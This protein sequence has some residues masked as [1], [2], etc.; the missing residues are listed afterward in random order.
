MSSEMSQ[1]EYKHH[2]SAVWRATII[3][4]VITIVEVGIALLYDLVLFTEG[5]RMPLNIFMILASAA[6]AFYIVGVFMHMKYERKAL[7][8]TVLV[9]TLFLVWA[10]IAFV[11]EGSAWLDMRGIWLGN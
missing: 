1:E 10:I 6:K 8:L 9:P 3:L 2:V 11:W 7:Q 5:P 4:S